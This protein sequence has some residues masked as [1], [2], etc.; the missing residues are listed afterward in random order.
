[1]LYSNVHIVYKK[2]AQSSPLFESILFALVEEVCLGRTEIDDFWTAV[3]IFLHR[4]ALLAVVSIRNTSSSADDTLTCVATIVTLVANAH[5]DCRL[6]HRVANNA[7]SSALLTK[8]SD[9][10][11]SLFPAHD[12]I[13]IYTK[14]PES[15]RL[16]SVG[17][18]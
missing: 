15:R 1:M 2:C 6:H 7:F 17:V 9:R 16:E 13:R 11:A 12:K 18:H 4:C 5:N 14:T 8:T 3:A 10:Y